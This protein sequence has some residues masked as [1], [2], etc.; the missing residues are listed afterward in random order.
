MEKSVSLSSSLG[1]SRDP[2]FTADLV[3][4]SLEMKSVDWME[5]TKLCGTFGSGF[6]Y[7]HREG[8]GSEVR[9][10]VSNFW[11]PRCSAP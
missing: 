6:I 9:W 11:R 8:G 7:H 10:L 4:L 3:S 1:N 2:I 5:L